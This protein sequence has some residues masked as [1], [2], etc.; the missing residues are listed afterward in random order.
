MTA[1]SIRRA[2]RHK[3]SRQ[4]QG[5]IRSRADP[6][7]VIGS[8]GTRKADA[9]EEPYRPGYLMGAWLKADEGAP[10]EK[11]EADDMVLVRPSFPPEVG[12]RARFTAVPNG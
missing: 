5:V 7:V 3:G 4:K 2:A 1:M 8:D 12:P 10:D 9:E 11:H 6:A